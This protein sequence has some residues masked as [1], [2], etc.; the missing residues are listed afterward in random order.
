MWAGL[1]HLLFGNALI[2]LL[3]G[4]IL[5][6]IY[7]LSYLKC[8][9]VMVVA[10]YFSSWGGG[11]FL[12]GAITDHLSLDLYNAWFW[13][14]TMVLVTYLLTLVLEWP[15]VFLCFRKSP[16]R[17]KRSLWGNLL[18]NSASYVLLF[19]WYWAASGTGI[20]RNVHVVQPSQMTMPTNGIVFYISPTNGDVYALNFKTRK[21]QKIYNFK[22]T[23]ANDRLFVRPSTFDINHWDIL[24]TSKLIQIQSNL[25]VTAK[26]SERDE[27][28]GTNGAPVNGTSFNFGETPQ[29]G[30]AENSNWKFRTGFWPNEGLTGNNSGTGASIDLALETPFVA[31][32][33]RNA[34]HLPGDYVVFQLGWDQICLLEVATRKIAVLDKGYGPIVVLQK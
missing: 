3:E 29:L 24:D 15:F 5:A 6:R 7:K 27:N 34:T 19:G 17:F 18:V 4:S 22:S 20:Y 28:I 8:I 14:W 25:A 9:L 2:G 1:L 10:N 33:A 13:F 11:V 32:A 21:S 31:W 23:D 26:P 16:D 12:D 30:A